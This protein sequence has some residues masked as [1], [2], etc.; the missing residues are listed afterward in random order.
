MEKDRGEKKMRKKIPSVKNAIAYIESCGWVFMYYNRPWY[1][2]TTKPKDEITG[3]VSFT[4][5]ELRD[6]L[7]NGW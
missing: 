3:W 6:C 2:F 5:H 4:L 1:V 7:V